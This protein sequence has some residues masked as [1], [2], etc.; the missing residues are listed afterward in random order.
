MDTLDCA[1]KEERLPVILS[2]IGKTKLLG[3]PAIPPPVSSK[4]LCRNY[5]RYL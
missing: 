1:S 3:V 4:E 5:G 2:G